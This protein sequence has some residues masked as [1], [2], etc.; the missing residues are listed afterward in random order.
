MLTSG[1]AGKFSEH[2]QLFPLKE[3]GSKLDELQV[4]PYEYTL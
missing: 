3:D 2:I 1:P 4:R